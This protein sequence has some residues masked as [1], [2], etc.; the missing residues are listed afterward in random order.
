MRTILLKSQYYNTPAA[1]CFGIHMFKL[2]NNW[3]LSV[4]FIIVCLFSWRYKPLWLYFRSPVAGFSIL[5]FEDSWSHTTTRHS[6]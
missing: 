5:V 6:R 2:Q 4:K 1:T 3:G